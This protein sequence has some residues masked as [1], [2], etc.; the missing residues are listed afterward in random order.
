MLSIY[1]N[2]AKLGVDSHY[3][4]TAMD[5]A[6]Y[7]RASNPASKEINPSGIVYAPGDVESIT[8]KE[9]MEKG[10]P[11]TQE[12]W[13]SLVAAAKEVGAAAPTL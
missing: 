3:I 6:D 5:F 12:V 2:P 13:D 7:V 4:Q 1:L 8:R 11:I 9:R 10:V